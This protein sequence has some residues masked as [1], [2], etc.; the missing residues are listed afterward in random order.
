MYIQQVF[1]KLINCYIITVIY[2]NNKTKKK[3][4]K[5]KFLKMNQ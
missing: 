2:D 1:G 5:Y 4:S 3:C